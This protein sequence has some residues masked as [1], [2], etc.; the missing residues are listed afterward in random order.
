[1]LP[2]CL[3]KHHIFMVF[4]PVGVPGEGA[5]VAVAPDMTGWAR[6]GADCCQETAGADGEEGP[7][8]ELDNSRI[9]L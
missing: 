8:V 9:D 7:G 6:R 4:T 1:M 3:L 5:G 2:P